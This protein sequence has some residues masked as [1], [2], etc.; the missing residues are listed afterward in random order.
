M[1]DVDPWTAFIMLTMWVLGAAAIVI[2]IDMLVGHGWAW[3]AGGM[4]LQATFWLGLA[5]STGEKP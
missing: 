3:L 2:G 4:I 5:T 1:K